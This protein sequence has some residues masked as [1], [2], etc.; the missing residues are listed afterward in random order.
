MHSAACAKRIV[1]ST[2]GSLGDINP[3]IGIALELKI[4]G[5]YRSLP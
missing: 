5:H 1:L 4:R 2:F 3:Y